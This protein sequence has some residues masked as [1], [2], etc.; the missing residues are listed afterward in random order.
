MNALLPK[1]YLRSCLG[2]LLALGAAAS[3]LGQNQGGEEGPI[4]T[5]SPFDINADSIEGYRTVDAT[6]ATRFR[7]PLADIPLNIQALNTEFISDTVSFDVAEAVEWASS[8]R[9]SGSS[10][11][12]FNESFNIRG[13]NSTFNLRN[14]TRVNGVTDTANI[15]SIEV[16]KGPSTVLFGVSQ[17]GGLVNFNT[18]Q[19]RFDRGGEFSYTY[20]TDEFNRALFDTY[21][22]VGNSESLAY[23]FIASY[24]NADSDTF[25]ELEKTFIA[26]SVEWRILP[27]LRVGLEYEFL[28]RNQ[29]GARKNGILP[30]LRGDKA[31][32]LP[33]FER[34]QEA[35]DKSF[36][37][38]LDIQ[39]NAFMDGQQ[40][41]GVLDVEWEATDW[42]TF[43]FIYQDNKDKREV[44]KLDNEAA[45]F[46][47]DGDQPVRGPRRLREDLNGFNYKIDFLFN[48]D[49]G[50]FGQHQILTGFEAQ[51]ETLHIDQLRWPNRTL[52]PI[53]AFAIEAAR[54]G[55]R[56]PLREVTDNFS[57]T[58]M[59]WPATYDD[60]GAFNVDELSAETTRADSVFI[61]D[62]VRFLEGDLHLLF[63]ARY[64]DLGPGLEQDFL[65]DEA[66]PTP[67]ED[68]VTFQVGALYDLVPGLAIFANYAE[69]FDE[70]GFGAQGEPLPPQT[71]DG[72]DVGFKFDGLL[73]GKLS[74][75]ATYFD[76]TREDIPRTLT[77]VLPDGSTDEETLL[78]GEEE[79]KGVD[80]DFF[81]RPVEN[82]QIQLAGAWIDSEVVSNRD[83]PLLEGRQNV[84]APKFQLR[85]FTSYEFAGGP[86]DGLSV[87]GGIDYQDDVPTEARS[88]RFLRKTDVRTLFDLFAKYRF[89][90]AERDMELQVN[91][92]NLFDEEFVARSS[93]FGDPFEFKVTYRVFF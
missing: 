78:S 75:T 79:A 23:R 16:I 73:G 83:D 58:T 50:A 14:G 49:G 62:M 56:E 66:T 70:N 19:P 9:R 82:W 18:K 22:P 80:F 90:M 3:L 6:G 32:E 41:F 81:Y 54:N 59:L 29:E 91:V 36:G 2:A 5:L 93:N 85:M 31:L 92:E 39:R 84:D 55:N 57:S 60:R 45:P 20:G 46:N 17:P 64:D 21:G 25:W 4:Y 47:T 12:D 86:L 38:D 24:T 11:N 77:I 65:D 40:Q 33:E 48:F 63:G 26:P 72:I 43:R 52:E 10:T 71:G 7:M 61:T 74:G 30:I 88:N 87:G 68:E 35:F 28:N 44:F 76:I 8:I 69:A 51:R 1:K 15:S 53:P 67:G 13:F 27:N 34:P 89:R 37:R 42:F